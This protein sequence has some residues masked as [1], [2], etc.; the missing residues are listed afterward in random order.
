MP[1]NIDRVGA[2]G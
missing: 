1:N 2:G